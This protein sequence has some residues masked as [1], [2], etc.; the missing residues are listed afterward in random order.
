ML[1]LD[2]YKVPFMFMMPDGKPMYRTLLGS[3]LSIITVVVLLSYAVY[4]SI[5]MGNLN[6]YK[7]KTAT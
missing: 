2:L 6:D 7:I 3:V 1:S 4:K 5:V